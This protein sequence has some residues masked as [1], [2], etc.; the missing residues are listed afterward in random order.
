MKKSYERNL[1][2]M[3]RFKITVRS[4]LEF[5]FGFPVFVIARIP[6]IV[7]FLGLPMEVV[8]RERWAFFKRRQ[9]KK[10]KSR[11]AMVKKS[12]IFLEHFMQTLKDSNFELERANLKAVNKLSIMDENLSD[13]VSELENHLEME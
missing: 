9:I 1:S 7:N 4:I 10:I 2:A 5:L 11:T 12:E 6:E 13:F 8:A 3:L